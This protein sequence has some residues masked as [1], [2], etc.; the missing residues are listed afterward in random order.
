M[1]G[2]LT[3]DFSL[4]YDLIKALKNREV[5]YISLSYT[6]PIPQNVD[7]ILTSPD[8]SKKIQFKKKIDCFPSSDLDV[9]I[10]KALLLTHP[11]PFKLMVGI[12]PGRTPGIAFFGNGRVLRSLHV[13]GPEGVLPLLQPL[14]DEYDPEDVIIRIG[15]GAPLMRNRIINSLQIL[16]VPMEIV[17][18]TSTS[19]LKTRRSDKAAASLIALTPGTLVKRRYSLTPK[20]GEIRDLQQKSRKLD[21]QVTISKE[22]AKKVLMGKMDLEEAIRKQRKK[23]I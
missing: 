13:K 16:T 12:D 21:G 4:Y 23:D 17:D 3:N 11:G 14:L 10:D 5:P 19:Y 7:V 6:E 22:L 1:I 8:E 9:I 2:I 15:H 20:K 18:E